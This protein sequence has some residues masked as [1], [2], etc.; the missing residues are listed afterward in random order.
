M[1]TQKLAELSREYHRVQTLRH[2]RGAPGD[3]NSAHRR[4]GQK[5]AD[6]ADR[7]ER[8]VEHWVGDHPLAE[9]WRRHFYDG[10]PAPDGPA[11]AEPPLFR[12]T[13]DAGARIEV[14][15]APA[16]SG[17]THDV[18]SDGKR[19]ARESS[20]WQLEPEAIEP[21][22]IVGR[23]CLD[24]VEA[25]PEAVGALRRFVEAPDSEPPWRFARELYEDGH[26]D[27]DF[28]L[29][30]R[31]RRCLAHLAAERPAPHAPGLAG[32]RAHYCVIA[33]DAAR[34]RILLLAAADNGQTAT[35]M[36][37]TE[38]ADM[39]RPEGRA[40]DRDLHAESRPPQRSDSTA[41]PASGHAVSDH[42]DNRRRW[43]SREFAESVAEAASRVWRTLP[44]CDVVVVASPPMLGLLRPAIARRN[45][46]RIP[47]RVSEL[48][49]DPA[50]SR[51]PRC[52]MRWRPPASCPRAADASRARSGSAAG[53]VV[54]RRGDRPPH[55]PPQLRNHVPAPGARP[56]DDVPL[57]SAR[58]RARRPG[59]G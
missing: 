31:G 54:I 57:R 38:V 23:V 50:S 55:P 3:G 20:P 42:R 39:K 59:P 28:A 32:S 34:A 30:P 27:V 45:G 11:L 40:H 46:G 5:M 24:T 9:T 41:R 44:L 15:R 21:V 13:N 52:T 36:P 51:P 2:R 19:I 33:A 10:A 35:L 14:R 56:R 4:L 37:L 1:L 8:Q 12:G 25:S 18:F 16:D 22:T 49:R 17:A 29:T 53:S 43:A 26:I 6:L 48:A 58:D 7:F 47:N